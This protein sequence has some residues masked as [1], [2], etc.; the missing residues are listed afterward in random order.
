MATTLLSLYNCKNNSELYKKIKE[1]SPEIKNL[2]NFINFL[3]ENQ[4]NENVKLESRKFTNDY[5]RNKKN[6]EKMIFYLN[7]NNEILEEVPTKEI[8]TKKI[9]KYAYDINAQR[10]ILAEKNKYENSIIPVVLEK[11]AEKMKEEMERFE[12]ELLDVVLINEKEEN[13]SLI[14]K[15]NP[16]DSIEQNGNSFSLKEQ[17][18]ENIK[19]EKD[20]HLKLK[21]TEKFLKYYSEKEM[22]RLNVL[23]EWDKIEENLKIELSE[24]NK[25]KFIFIEINKNGE[26]IKKENLFEGTINFSTVYLREFGKRL[27]NVNKG[28]SI[29]IAHNHPSGTLKASTADILITRKIEKMCKFAEIPLLEHYIISK[30]GIFSFVKEKI[31][32][33]QYPEL[34]DQI[35][36]QNQKGNIR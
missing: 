5:I 31:I 26:I 24:L 34:K 29:M 9:I 27:L 28:N 35:K 17:K 19:I 4:K 7:G 2:K 25:E 6:I 3:A 13:I 36:K 14:F 8:D 22:K 32:D 15:D 21:G 16:I 20:K 12:I 18:N 33:N 1:N 23:T 30:H 10:V 11:K